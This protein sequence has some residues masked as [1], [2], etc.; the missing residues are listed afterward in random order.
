MKFKKEF[1]VASFT[2]TGTIIGAG[3]LG[4]PF[5][6]FQSGFLVGVFWLIVLG[7]IMMF[8]NLCL[9]EV[10]LRT[11]SIHQLPGYAE[12]Y[13][14]KW[15]KNVMLFA[16]MFGIYAALLAY[17]IGEGQSF[18]RL[19]FGD[20]KYSIYFAIGFWVVMT[21]LLHEG[22][23]GL[24]RVETWGVL[25]IISVL[26]TMLVWFYPNINL[27]NLN[28]YNFSNLFL[29]FGILLFAL[30]GFSSIPEL[31]ME[32]KN[33]E[34]LLKKAILLGS[35][36]PVFLYFI[37]TLIILG[38]LGND[39]S[40]IATLSF[41]KFIVVLGIFAMLTSYFVLSFSL[42]DI[43]YYDLNKKN[44]SFL[45]V[46]VIPLVIYLLATFFDLANFIKIL[47][48]GGVVSGGLAGI[49]ILLMNLRAKKK[50][51]RKP[52]FSVPTNWIIIGIFSL[53]FLAG[54]FTEL[55]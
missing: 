1:W 25:A 42:R 18:S 45:F 31:R 49:L 53:I 19:F 7:M 35:L 6:F 14:G 46:S 54:I 47:G 30:L 20:L 51:E 23:R 22:L 9:G 52:E 37:F 33:N 34:K 17:L 40:E 41:G 44:L 43:F 48:I 12:K 21:M 5:V 26:L 39:V 15:G 50:G 11:K 29:P 28:Y 8:V 4:L 36:I 32:I 10:T 16:V 38:V 27:N 2:L 55:F 24:K 3:I 13:I